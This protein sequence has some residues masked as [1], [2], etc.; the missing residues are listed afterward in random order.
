MSSLFW[1]KVYSTNLEFLASFLSLL[2]L[3]YRY[4]EIGIY[5]VWF[6]LPC[7]TLRLGL[8][9]PVG[10]DG[11]NAK[12]LT[13]TAGEVFD[14]VRLLCHEAPFELRL[15]LRP[16]LSLSFKQVLGIMKQNSP[17]AFGL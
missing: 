5:G 7:R 8:P 2:P 14:D 4:L 6:L 17:F 12:N 9:I 11:K 13:T 16:E 15:H 1:A 3:R 10:C